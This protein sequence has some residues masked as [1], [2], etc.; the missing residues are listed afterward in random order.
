MPVWKCKGTGVFPAPGH[1][2]V[3]FN[4]TVT[5]LDDCK[6]NNL[7]TS[8]CWILT[9]RIITVVFREPPHASYEM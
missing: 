1:S 8:G 9:I 3:I 2:D 5:S 7:I 6:I 4:R